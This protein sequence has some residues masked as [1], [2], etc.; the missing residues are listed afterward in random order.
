M[1]MMVVAL[2]STNAWAWPWNPDDTDTANQWKLNLNFENSDNDNRITAE[3]RNSFIAEVFDY[4]TSPPSY[5]IFET[6][7]K[8]DGNDANFAQRFD[9]NTGSAGDCVLILPNDDYYEDESVPAYSDFIDPCFVTIGKIYHKRTW[10]FWVYPVNLSSGTFIRQQHWDSTYPNYWWEIRLTGGRLQF[11]QNYREG[12]TNSALRMQTSAVA[13]EYMT[14]GAWHHVVVVIDRTA[15]SN[16][17]IY[18]NGHE[19]PVNYLVYSD[20]EDATIDYENRSHLRFGKGAA[21]FDGRLDEIRLYSRALNATEA[22]I[23]YQEQD[24]ADPKPIAV[25]PIPRLENVSADTDLSWAPAMAGKNQ[26]IYFGTDNPPATQVATG[27]DANSVANAA[28]NGGNLLAAGVTYYWRVRTNT[29]GLTWVYGPTW[30]FTT[31]TGAASNPSPEDGATHV[32]GTHQIADVNLSWTGS[33]LATDYTVYFSTDSDLVIDGDSS[34]ILAAGLT[35]EEVNVKSPARNAVCYWRVDCNFSGVIAEGPIWTFRTRPYEIVINTKAKEFRQFNYIFPTY[36]IRVHGDGWYS[37]KPDGNEST[38]PSQPDVVGTL[39]GGMIVFDFNT[40]NF[41][42]RFEIVVIPQYRG[43]EVNEFTIPRPI[44]INVKNGGNFYFDGTM[45]ISGADVVY[46][47][48]TDDELRACSGG[49]P[50]PKRNQYEDA[51]NGN[52]FPT[53]T[54]NFADYWTICNV[55]AGNY[56][57]FGTYTSG[58][59]LLI[60]AASAIHTWGPGHPINPPYKGG[61]G[62]GHAGRGG[63]GGRSYSAGILGGA[64]YGSKEVGFPFGGSSGGWGGVDSPGGCPGGGGIEIAAEGNVTLDGNSIILAKGG[65]STE[66][67]GYRYSNGGGAGGSVRIIGTDVTIKGIIN[68]DGGKGGNAGSGEG[69][70]DTGGGGSAG[71]I[72]IFFE[73]DLDISQATLSSQGGDRGVL[74][75]SDTGIAKPGASS[76]PY[77]T[78]ESPTKASDPIPADGDN[79]VYAAAGGTAVTLKWMAGFGAAS[80]E[81]YFGTT[82][83]PV[84]KVGS[85]V[86]SPARGQRSAT[87]TENIYPGNTY[88]VQ[89]KSD[90]SVNSDVWSFSTVGWKCEF[91]DGNSP[92][93]K[94]PSWDTNDDCVV[95]AEDF[96]FYAQDWMNPDLGDLRLGYTSGGE[97]DTA[98]STLYRF[99]NEWLLCAGRTGA[100]CTGWIT[101]P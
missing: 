43:R 69:E 85:S 63:Q 57:R 58:K 97:G 25:S 55:T 45:N 67:A 59:P 89:V 99:V 87:T 82:N 19:E 14:I 84:T 73:D 35:V 37:L 65:S 26:Q 76:E 16:S 32:V 54:W 21:E 9:E 52:V 48:S 29:S 27:A 36:G 41:D 81:V 86:T 95:N 78:D 8:I 80:D 88:Y 13:S 101:L 47:D 68:V 1:L 56:T 17:K 79:Q 12:A 31:E 34:A 72:A 75:G 24:V 46:A 74:S 40:F 83:P 61:S 62:G 38:H 64:S 15:E 92:Y 20:T 100:G 5:A 22:S 23:L 50:G 93:V 60:P 28:L 77:I 3:L 70:N 11:Y 42:K 94:G 96:W 33:S 44:A 6:N 2:V 49:F 39:Q 7:G 4:N 10:S 71:R 90:G 30:S 91:T 18:V 66:P 98:L 51:P 53:G